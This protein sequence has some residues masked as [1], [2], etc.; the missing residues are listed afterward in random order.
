[1]EKIIK[2]TSYVELRKLI[3]FE[4]TNKNTHLDLGKIIGHSKI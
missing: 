3:K 1:M 4:E 2:L